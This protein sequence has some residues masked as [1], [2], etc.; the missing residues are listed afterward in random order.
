MIYTTKDLLKKGETE[1][2]IK[3][4]LLSGKL[5]LIERGMYSDEDIFY[6]DEAYICK[7][8]PNAIITGLSAFAIYDLT[9]NIPDYF[10]LCTEQHSFPIRRK[11]VKQSYQDSSF[12][13]VG[14][15]NIET[16]NGV[17]CTYDLERLFIELIRLKEKYPKDL[18]HEVLSSFRRVKNKLDYYKL[19]M[20]CKYFS[21]NDSLIAKI[22]EI[23]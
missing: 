4:K 23:L 11:D 15:T 2:S 21:N 14:K 19:N 5:V 20:Y 1:Y 10:F 17:I 7:K 16:K 13:E 22:Q 12:F 9:D 8:Y 18:Y 6:V 3:N